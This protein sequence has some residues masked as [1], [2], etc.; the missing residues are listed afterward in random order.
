MATPTSVPPPH[1]THW[2]KPEGGYSLLWLLFLCPLLA[3][4][5]AAAGFAWGEI[6]FQKLGG[7]W[8]LIF[9]SGAA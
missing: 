5:Q 6:E 7:I 8:N 9:A 2:W 3:G 1:L 4:G